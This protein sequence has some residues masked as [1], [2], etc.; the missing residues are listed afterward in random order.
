MG[1]KCS[2]IKEV[3][4][5]HEKKILITLTL[6]S[7]EEIRIPERVITWISDFLHSR[8][9]TPLSDYMPNEDLTYKLDIISR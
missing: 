4:Q 8:I 9:E 6:E 5:M 7:D 2:T 1:S 3:N